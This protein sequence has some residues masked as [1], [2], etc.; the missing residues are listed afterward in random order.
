MVDGGRVSTTRTA[1]MQ[2]RKLLLM[3]PYRPQHLNDA[4]R[5]ESFHVLSRYSGIDKKKIFK[6]D[7]TA[8]SS[9]NK[10][11]RE[12]CFFYDESVTDD[13]RISFES[14]Y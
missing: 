5:N 7:G 4:V 6:K 11:K 1:C 14:N 2:M 10:K 8:A 12:T 13:V 9:N 3:K